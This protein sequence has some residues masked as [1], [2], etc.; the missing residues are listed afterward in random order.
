MT[1]LDMSDALDGF[2][3]NVTFTDKSTFTVD[4]EEFE[5]VTE[6]IIPAVIQPAQ[7][8]NLNVADVD[9]S[10]EYILIHST[11]Q[12]KINYFVDWNGKQFRIFDLGNYTDYCFFEAI[13]EEVKG[14]D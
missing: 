11:S 14:D 13:A 3:Q 6:I 8:E 5:N 2:E 1:I 7:K 4:F 9:W 10:K 12:L